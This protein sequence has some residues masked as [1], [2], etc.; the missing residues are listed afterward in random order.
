M[1]FCESRTDFPR[2]RHTE[3]H[4]LAYM[5]KLFP[6]EELLRLVAEASQRRNANSQHGNGNT[7][8]PVN[9]WLDDE[10]LRA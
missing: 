5:P 2:F 10:E 4:P 7:A 9:P 1:N 8:E 3:F 6:M